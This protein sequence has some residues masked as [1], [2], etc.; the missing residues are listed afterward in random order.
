MSY[1]KEDI[2]DPIDRQLSSLWWGVI[3]RAASKLSDEI[4]VILPDGSP[5]HQ[6]GP[7][8]WQ[9]RDSFSLPQQ[10]DICLFSFDNRMQPWVVSWWPKTPTIIVDIEHRVGNAGEP[11]YGNNWSDYSAGG[12]RFWKDAQGIVFVYG[13]MK[14]T[15]N[16]DLGKTAWSLPV[17][18]R[19]LTTLS[20]IV[21]SITQPISAGRM[22]ISAA[23]AI[24]PM[25]GAWQGISL[26]G[27]TFKAWQ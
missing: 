5:D 23:G 26:S 13:A 14:G 17:G 20:F 27:V 12:S 6:I 24:I 8:R 4:Y 19:P 15:G 22:D 7:C 2:A 21:T 10:G 3:A 16:S 9:S 25:E 1:L 18:Y 11:S